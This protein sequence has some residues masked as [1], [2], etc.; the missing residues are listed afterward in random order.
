MPFQ[1]ALKQMPEYMRSQD[2]RSFINKE[3][4]LYMSESVRGT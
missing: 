1:V 3:S 4:S 2:M